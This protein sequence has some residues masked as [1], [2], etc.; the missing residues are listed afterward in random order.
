[1][2]PPEKRIEIAFLTALS[3][4]PKPHE[5]TWCAELL[6]RQTERAE[7]AKLSPE[8]ASHQALAHLCHMLLNTNEFLYVP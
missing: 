2:A 5:T 8:Q 1:M 6:R 3:R 4:T 7:A